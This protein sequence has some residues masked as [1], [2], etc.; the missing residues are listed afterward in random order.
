[1]SEETETP[2]SADVAGRLDGLVGQTA[3]TQRGFV[4]A[5]TAI[6]RPMHHGFFLTEWEAKIQRDVIE[7][8]YPDSLKTGLA[9]VPATLSFEWP[10]AVLSGERTE[11]K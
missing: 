6:Y 10:N 11:E 8:V 3:W 1:M 4:L 9:I 7:R 2:K 5:S